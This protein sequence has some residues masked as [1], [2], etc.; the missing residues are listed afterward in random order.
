[1]DPTAAL[2]IR[3]MG[4]DPDGD[5]YT[6]EYTVQD[7]LDGAALRRLREALPYR[8]EASWRH[9]SAGRWEDHW[10]MRVDYEVKDGLDY[11]DSDGA[12]IA[13]AADK[14]REALG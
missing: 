9:D 10:W 7:A 11:V 5:A 1:M 8:I 6:S 2:L 3:A 13:A 14:C 12:T 4:G